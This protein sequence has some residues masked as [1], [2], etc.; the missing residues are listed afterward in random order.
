MK[1]VMIGSGNTG[2]VLC[3]V[4]NKAD[5]Q[6]VQVVSR[7]VE[8]ARKLAEIYNASYADLTQPHFA[9]ADI[10]ILALQDVALDH[11]GKYPGLKNKLVVHTAG[12]VSIVVL[13]D[14]SDKYGVMYPLQTLS[15]FT[16]HIP[17]IP[18]LVDGSDKETLH[19]ILGLA[20]SISTNVV[21][22]DDKERLNYHVAAVF[23]SNFANHMFAL[24]EIFC[25]KEKLEFKSL[26]PL[27]NEVNQRV[28]HHSPF[29][30]QTGPAMRDD[31]FT[32]NRHLQA[33][34]AYPE[35]K[36]IYLKVSESIIKNHG[37]R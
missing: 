11:L 25:Q 9:E 3:A 18:F 28:N 16:D 22:A 27:V 24:A 20:K 26:I 5:H 23:V 1:V 19:Q 32:L 36:Y 14:I 7:N 15:K 37:K 35:L 29:L 34:T 21:T 4:L 12:A 6:I 10:Y 31:I 17:E 33:L 2:T 13:K 30:T 8:N